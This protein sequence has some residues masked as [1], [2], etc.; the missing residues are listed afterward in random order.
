LLTTQG[1]IDTRQITF[2]IATTDPGRL[3]EAF[4]SRVSKLDLKE[5]SLSEIVEVLKSHRDRSREDYPEEVGRFDN[6]ALGVIGTVGR[7]VPRQALLCFKEAGR[8]VRL[9][10]AEPTATDL[11]RYFRET[12]SA[13]D[14]G[15]TERDW[16]YLQLLFPDLRR[17]RDA[18]AAAMGE[19]PSTVEF[20]IEPFLLRLGMIERERGGRCLTA[21]GREAV[22]RHNRG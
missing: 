1:E 5:Y 14:A 20:D 4:K 17:G 6:E 2:I 19:D 18:L 9:R 12:R 13:D 8:A 3:R 7:F 16:R 10:D 15:L 22:G 11:R 21:D